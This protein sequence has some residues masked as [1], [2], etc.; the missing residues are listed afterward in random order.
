M[1]IGRQGGLSFCF[2][3]CRICTYRKDGPK[4]NLIVDILHV[5]LLKTT[6]MSDGKMNIL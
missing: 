3:A 2:G 5:A 1:G 6:F 4:W